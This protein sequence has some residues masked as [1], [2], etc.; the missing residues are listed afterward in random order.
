MGVHGLAG[1]ADHLGVGAGER[2]AV[3]EERQ[4]V[5]V[6]ARERHSRVAVVLV[7]ERLVAERLHR[8]RPEEVRGRPAGDA[9]RGGRA[10][11]A[12]DGQGA[13]RDERGDRTTGGRMWTHGGDPSFDGGRGRRMSRTSYLSAVPIG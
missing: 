12:D 8:V 3:V 7:G 1:L 11:Q 5:G 13:G 6:V 10:D 9:R 2:A 4:G